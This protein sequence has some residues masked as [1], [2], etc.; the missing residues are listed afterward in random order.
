MTA[1][2]IMCGRPEA[3]WRLWFQI[4]TVQIAIERQVEIQS[5]LLAV[6]NHI[7]TRCQL[8]LHRNGYGI[9]LQFRTIGR[10]SA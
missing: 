3:P 2:L 4:D 6:R 8:I 7:Q 10:F 9:F 1:A 5:R